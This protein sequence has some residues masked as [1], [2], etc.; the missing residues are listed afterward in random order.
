MINNEIIST[1]QKASENVAVFISDETSV[2]TLALR[3]FCTG[4]TIAKELAGM[5]N[6]TSPGYAITVSISCG[7]ILLD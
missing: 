5:P 7:A 1:P 3:M 4:Y 2:F 6:V